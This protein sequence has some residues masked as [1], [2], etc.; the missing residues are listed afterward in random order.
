M[1]HKEGQLYYLRFNFINIYLW[2]CELF[3]EFMHVSNFQILIKSC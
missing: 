1:L 2:A 3:Y